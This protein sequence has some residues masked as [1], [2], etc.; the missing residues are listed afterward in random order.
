[1]VRALPPGRPTAQ[2]PD[3]AGLGGPRPP[4]RGLLHEAHGERRAAE[5]LVKAANGELP[6]QREQR[7]KALGPTFAQAAEGY[8]WYLENV[9]RD[10]FSTVADYRTVVR[11]HLGPEFGERR[12]REITVKHV[13]GYKE[14]LLAERRLSPRSIVRCL[15][16]LHGIFDRAEIEPN[17]ASAK[18]VPR[19]RV[20]YDGSFQAYE[21][22]EVKLLAAAAAD[23]QEATLIL[24]AAYTG[25]R[26][27]ELL[28]LKWSD[29]D[30]V[31][32]LLHA[33]RSWSAKEGKTKTTKGKTVR[34]VPMAPEVV[35]A[36]AR[37]KERPH[38]TGDD[39]YVFIDSKGDRRDTA[40]VRRQWYATRKR[41]A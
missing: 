37:L 21:P 26:Q 4:A 19:P 6:E 41:Q 27:G 12:L 31:G 28:A 22:E 35:E 39:D 36:L 10:D 29:V 24:T 2:P 18:L 8:L 34:S 23:R 25:L 16:V 9:K 20:V 13:K 32:G 30:F 1:L 38:F 14:R 11:L 3:R 7:D 17:P 33:Q 15:V 40:R 5:L